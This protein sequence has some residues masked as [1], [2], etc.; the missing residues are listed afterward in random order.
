MNMRTI[1]KEVYGLAQVG[2][3][4]QSLVYDEKEI[5]RIEIIN[6]DTYG[7]NKFFIIIYYK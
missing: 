6:V 3:E 2:V 1:K 7:G 5:E 4:I